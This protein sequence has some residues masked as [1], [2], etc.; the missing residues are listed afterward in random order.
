MNTEPVINLLKGKSSF[1]LWE[2]SGSVSNRV[3]PLMVFIERHNS[4]PLHKFSDGTDALKTSLA[5]A[6]RQSAEQTQW[7]YV[8]GKAN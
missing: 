8:Q 2:S 7:K 6:L 1:M 4:S 5:T 3:A